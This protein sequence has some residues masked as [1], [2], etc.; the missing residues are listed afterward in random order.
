MR[1]CA[2]HFA[3]VRGWGMWSQSRALL[4]QESQLTCA[5]RLVHFL[6]VSSAS[7]LRSN[8][9]GRFDCE[10][11][12]TRTDLGLLCGAM[13]R[14]LVVVHVGVLVP[15]VNALQELKG[16]YGIWPGSAG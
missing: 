7:M 2:A 13:V 5:A 10:E 12:S 16:C 11:Y 14:H 8:L 3:L 15:V 9:Q 4:Q 1:A 6:R